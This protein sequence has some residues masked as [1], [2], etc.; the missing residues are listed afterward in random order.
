VEAQLKPDLDR[1]LI[2]RLARSF[3]YA[4]RGLAVVSRDRMFR[5]QLLAAIM[6]IALA[7]WLRM[8]PV[9]WSI[10]ALTIG[11]VLALEAMNSAIETSVDL[12][13]PEMHPS[14]ARAKDVAAGA[15]LIASIAAAVVGL[16]ILGPK[17]VHQLSR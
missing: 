6:V 14:A 9:E 12:A 5:C 4:L 15:V 13:M 11:F 8:T 3:G 16:F 1:S 10:L 2:V 7:T 17:I